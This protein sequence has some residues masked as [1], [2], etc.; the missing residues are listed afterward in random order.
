MAPRQVSSTQSFALRSLK[1]GGLPIANRFLERLKFAQLVKRH[2]PPPDPRT[3]LAPAKALGVLLRN[4]VLSRMPL[5]S[6]SEWARDIEPGLLDLQDEEIALINDD[7]IGRSL[8]RLF[9]ADRHAML[10]DF[11]VHMVKEFQVELEQFHNDSTTITLYGDYKEADGRKVRGKPTILATQGHNKD[12]RPDLKQL[13]WILTVSADGMV[14]VHFKVADG[15]T[16]DSTTHIETWQV[17]RRLVGNVDFLYVADCK[18]CTREN[19]RYIEKEHGW[20][21]TLLPRTRG[22]DSSFRDWL[23]INDPN[24]QDIE[25]KSGFSTD[26]GEPEVI[27]ALESPIPDADGFR[28]VWVW[29]SLKKE[30]DFQARKNCIERAFK[31]LEELRVKLESPRCRFTTKEGVAKVADEIIARSGASRWIGYDLIQVDRE[32]FRQEKRGRS[33]E[34]TRWRRSLKATFSLTVTAIPA[35][36]DYDMKCDGI[37]PLITNRRVLT[38]YQVVEVYKS[39]HPHIEKRHHLLKSVLSAAPAFLKSISRL[40]ALLFLEYVALTVHALIEREIRRA[41]AVHHVKQLP[42][43][44]EQRRCQAPTADRILEIFD[45]LQR[46]RLTTDTGH[47]VQEFDPELSGLQMQILEL[48]Q[49]PATLFTAR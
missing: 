15:N 31:G 1:L 32:T 22:E 47:P 37:F 17:L 6:Q 40:E 10:T 26:D 24:W 35:N 12:H 27:R 48:L 11:V 38:L 5:Y 7:R 46:H 34:N 49:I 45:G 28:L 33:G 30:R 9:D 16:E 23:Q 20:F 36:I 13:L 44:P 4:L 8:D 21:L 39:K 18:L 29:S 42:L 41:M 3:E 14:P 43:Y 25:Y 2:L 19:L